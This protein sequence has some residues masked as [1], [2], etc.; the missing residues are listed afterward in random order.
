MNRPIS[1]RPDSTLSR[2]PVPSQA[3]RR[4]V[5]G[6]ILLAAAAAGCNAARW[7]YEYEFGRRRA[8]DEKKLLILYFADLMTNEHYEINRRLFSEPAV[9][10]E[11]GGTVNV[12]LNYK[13]GPAPKQYRITQPLICVFCD[14]SGAELSRMRL[15]PLP[16]PAEFA[17]KVAELKAQVAPPPPTGTPA[18]PPPKSGAASPQ[19]PSV[20]PPAEK[21]QRQDAGSKADLSRIPSAGRT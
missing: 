6:L 17:K 9:Q 19:Q 7:D 13:W 4:R 3:R 18:E 14:P 11:L 8:G 2:L 20:P 15:E 1:T 10:R 21:N 16:A 12:T 5:L